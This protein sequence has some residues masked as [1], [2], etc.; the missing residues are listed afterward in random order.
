MIV[1]KTKC[2]LL[3]NSFGKKMQLEIVFEKENGIPFPPS[4]PFGLFGPIPPRPL[5]SPFLGRGPTGHPSHPLPPLNLSL[6]P[7]HGAYLS[8]PSSPNRLLPL[9][10]FSKT[11]SRPSRSPRSPLLS[12]AP[13]IQV[14]SDRARAALP[15]PHFFSPRLRSTRASAE[16]HRRSAA[17]ILRAPAGQTEPSLPIFFALVSSPPLPHSPRP[18]PERF[19][20]S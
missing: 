2:I 20:A 10:R 19:G 3:K 8:A 9:S 4:S 7:T 6:S 17:V 16:N 12:P 14:E 15:L 13:R 11:A 1:L 18:F 5:F